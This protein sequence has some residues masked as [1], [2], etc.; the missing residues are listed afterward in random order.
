MEMK[1]LLAL[2]AFV[3]I[4]SAYETAHACSCAGFPSPCGAYA[5]ADA[6]FVG[7]VTK[8]KPANSAVEEGEQVAFVQ[9]ERAFKGTQDAEIVLHQP[10]H[11]CAPK[12]KVGDRWLMYATRHEESKTWEVYGCGRSARVQS[13][14][15]DLLYLQ[16][17]PESAN[18]TRISG[19]IE[20]YEDDPEK[21]FT[22]VGAIAGAKVRIAGEGKNYEVTTDSNGVYELYG[23]PPG[24]YTI[25]P[26]IPPG[27]K[28]RFPM[29]FGAIAAAGKT[30]TV[31]L[32]P[33]SC[34][35]SNF[36]LSSD[37]IVGGRILGTDGEIMPR[38][39]VNIVPAD[40]KSNSNF[41]EF[42]CTEKDGRFVIDEIP[43]GKYLLV[44][45]D[46]GEISGNEPFP[47]VYFPG[48]F[49]KEKAQVITVNEGSRVEDYD[50]HIPAQLPTRIV[51]GVLL[52]SDGTPVARERVEFTAEGVAPPP[53]KLLSQIEKQTG[54]MR[55][56]RETSG[57][58]DEEGRFSL[59]ILQ[60]SAGWINGEMYLYATKYKD[61]PQVDKIVRKNGEQMMTALTNRV[62]L[63]VKDNI[64][65][66]KL[67]FK[68][69][70][71][72]RR[73]VED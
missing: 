40:K 28:I 68:F 48:V 23:L 50:I 53:S 13:A 21:G 60:G 6:V 30:L 2:I 54:I 29:A 57:L 66:V 49:D 4:L 64:Q 32:L 27:L 5:A 20:H 12:F 38:V 31:E 37:T 67:Q 43:P 25:K 36:L 1:K 56:E 72:A 42:D 47:I 71:C 7:S 69:P 14:N 58:T 19:E 35:G 39:C 61:C 45:N 15:D 17:L 24:K 59:K 22:S 33:N 65:D 70:F 18:T 16:K 26:E 3:L 73:K 51:Q 41:S 8:V 11:N 34:A 52:F 44:V 10:G 46:D 62:K 9:V 63:E 55:S